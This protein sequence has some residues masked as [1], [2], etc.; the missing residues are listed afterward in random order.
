[1][2]LDEDILQE[3][4][5]FVRGGFNDRDE[6][7]TICCEEM[8]EPGELD[9]QEVERV[10]DSEFAAV[11][12]ELKSWPAVTDCDKLD[13]VFARLNERNI[14]ALQNAGYTQSDGHEDVFEAY[15]RHPQKARIAGYC[16]YHGQ[17]LARA[18]DGDGLY[19][20]FGPIDPR[21]E[22][23]EG[24]AI[25]AAIVEELKRAGFEVDW[26]GTFAKRICVPKLDW[27]RRVRP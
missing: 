19:L 27:K 12:R 3:I 21:R 13:A 22:E 5:R 15:E 23:S 11:A 10:V 2:P 6:I 8:Y 25:G 16:F 24:P 18:V 17:D 14:I 20:A 9:Q 4:R 7:V 26:N 1:M